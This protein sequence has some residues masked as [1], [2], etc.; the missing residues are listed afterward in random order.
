MIRKLKMKKKICKILANTQTDRQLVE[1]QSKKMNR[2][3]SNNQQRRTMKVDSNNSGSN[4][5][6]IRPN[7]KIIT[8]QV[9]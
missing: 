7:N 6:V 5:V 4:M 9:E 8:T 2:E 1:F 3:T